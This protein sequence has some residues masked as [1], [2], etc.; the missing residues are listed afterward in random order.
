VTAPPSADRAGPPSRPGGPAWLGAAGRRASAVIVTARPKQWPKNLL[1]LA[2]PLAAAAQGRDDGA[3]YALLAVAAFTAASC[4][5]YFVNDVVDAGRDRQHPVKCRRPVAAGTLPAGQALAAGAA[6][7]LAALAAGVIAGVP[8]LT[9]TVAAYLAVS[10]LYSLRLKHVPGLELACVASGFVLRALG[11]AAATS[12]RPSGWFLAV[13]GL[14]ALMVAVA[15]RRGELARPGPD[16]TA[17][18][19]VLDWYRPR[20]LVLAGRLIAAA[21]IACYSLWA[22]T[23]AT[24]A[25]QAWHVAS[26]VPLAVALAR[27]DWLSGRRAARPVEDLIGADRVMAA[28]ELAW[29]ALFALGLPASG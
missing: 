27:F 22:I 17:H 23:T 7:G 13:C 4:T 3:G 9:V 29:L 20:A 6:A 14:G 1:V 10:F 26:I 5:V 11:G 18:R 8:W 2:A 21:V 16:V 12:I 24:G 15:K 28:A 25:R 19:P